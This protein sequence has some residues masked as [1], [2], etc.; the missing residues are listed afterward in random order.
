MS[1]VHFAILGDCSL[2]SLNLTLARNQT[3]ATSAN[4]LNGCNGYC[5][6]MDRYYLQGA[7]IAEAASSFDLQEEISAS[8]V[9]R[10][11]PIVRAMTADSNSPLLPK[12]HIISMVVPEKRARRQIAR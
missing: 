5:L 3:T 2:I 6:V 10:I 9:S 11:T 8:L 1:T 12:G 4:C 7:H